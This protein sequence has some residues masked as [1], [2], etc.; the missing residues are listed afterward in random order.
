MDIYNIFLIHRLIDSIIVLKKLFGRKGVSGIE[1]K[2]AKTQKWLRT[3][4]EF[5]KILILIIYFI[6]GSLVR[7]SEILL[8]IYKNLSMF[9]RDIYIDNN[10]KLIR[11]LIRY[12]KMRV[13]IGRECSTVRF[14][15]RRISRLVVHYLVIGLFFY[16]YL[17][18]IRWVRDGRN[19]LISG[20][21]FEDGGERFSDVVFG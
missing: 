7:G 17:N 16:N 4:V 5:L 11:M 2:L 10:V 13:I 19:Y 12:G 6:S 3:R 1:L 20:L 15:N 21:L 14:I 18:I 8:V 9:M